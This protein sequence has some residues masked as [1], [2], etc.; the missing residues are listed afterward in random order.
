M[1]Q[2]NSAIDEDVA[3]AF[4]SPDA[5]APPSSIT[6][7]P[8][9]AEAFNSSAPGAK[10]PVEFASPGDVIAHKVGDAVTY[11]PKKIIAGYHGLFDLAT[12]KGVNKATADVGADQGDVLGAMPPIEPG[13]AAEFTKNALE[14]NAN[15][16]NWPG[17]LTS[18]HG[19]PKH[20]LDP[21]NRDLVAPLN[22]ATGDIATVVALGS[23]LAKKA[24]KAAEPKPTLNEQYEGQSM[25]AAGAAP[26]MLN[27]TPELR[28]RVQQIVRDGGTVNKEA[29]ARHVEA[30]SLP[31]PAKLTRGQ[32]LQDPALMSDE[33]NAKGK[34]PEIGQRIAEQNAN[35]VE[36][37]QTIREK[38]GPDV[39]STNAVEHGDTLIDS[40]K[41]KDAAIRSDISAKYQALRDANGGEFPVNGQLFATNADAALKANMKAPF[42]PSGVRSVMQ[43]LRDGDPM[44][45]E[46]FENLRTT[47]A[48]EARKAARAGDGN[49]EMAVNLVRDQL[50]SLPMEGGS[51]QIK[52]LADQARQAAK[53]RFDALRAD[54]AYK[55]AVQDTVAPDQFVK[56]FIVNGTR[57]NVETMAENLKENPVAK[58]TMGVAALDHLR[59]QA[60]V[61]NGYFR[62]S[63]YNKY[64]RALDAKIPSLF[65]PDTAQHLESV[66]NVARWQQQ[67]LP[68]S[69]ANNSHTFVAAAKEQAASALEGV[70]NVKAGGL[71][72][73]TLIRKGLQKRRA[74]LETSKVLEP[75][76]GIE[77]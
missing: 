62:Q 38:V 18:S 3:S 49:A 34:V 13:S 22:E 15:P 29:L 68:G 9:V 52:M 35:L 11:L 36:N 60:G 1:P 63:G 4:A 47:L 58:Q 10:A 45:F 66:G 16:L 43:G 54:P 46:N 59:E 5:Q 76:A 71:P 50:E 53:A 6:V 2:A 42:L 48:A 32:A 65:D 8:D 21:Y 55:A 26:N 77:Q 7:D 67:Q 28:D 51:V 64:L 37:L 30:E 40:Y 39:F 23:G 24:T 33:F 69:Y 12:G 73:G 74:A 31:V 72:V 17:L 70:A 57:D 20:S 56:K 61:N 44:T 41:A 75:G 14:S 19:A 25:G 27:A